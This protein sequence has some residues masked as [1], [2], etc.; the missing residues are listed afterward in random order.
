MQKYKMILSYDGTDFGGWQVQPNAVTIQET[1]QQAFQTLLQKEV[2]V[3]GSGRTDAGVHA[4]GQ[5]AHFSLEAPLEKTFLR[6]ALN[7]NLPHSIR[8]KEI[9]PVSDQFHARY[10]AKEKTYHYNLHVHPIQSPFDRLYSTHVRQPFNLDLLKEAIPLFVG[11]HDFTSFANEAFSGSAAKDPVRTLYDINITQR[12]D[13]I[14]LEFTGNGFLYKMVRN[15]VG[16]LLEIA[17][18]KRSLNSIPKLFA[19][20]DRRLAPAPAPSRGLF[21]VSVKYS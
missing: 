5:V 6:S 4:L 9:Q 1:L 20:K 18:E 2:F 13:Q 15:L 17:A 19:Q 11:T 14:R 8:I 10:S 12:E 3:T 21:L 7:G 16:I